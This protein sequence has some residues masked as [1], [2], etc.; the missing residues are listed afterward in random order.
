MYIS[1]RCVYT[2]DK[3][4]WHHWHTRHTTGGL[5][6]TRSHTHRHNQQRCPTGS[7]WRIT[8]FH[9][10]WAINHGWALASLTNQP[11]L[12]GE[13]THILTYT[14]VNTHKHT[15]HTHTHTHVHQPNLRE[16]SMLWLAN[17]ELTQ[18]RG[19]SL[20]LLSLSLSFL[21]P[22]HLLSL[23]LCEVIPLC[24]APQYDAEQ[25]RTNRAPKTTLVL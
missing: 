6:C 19:L 7:Q 25:H 4:L 8:L 24:K 14:H 10:H 22:S 9:T 23:Q 3:R 20:L 16:V 5:I 21:F 12:T 18:S 11:N 17:R 1:Y 13:G 2:C 15:V